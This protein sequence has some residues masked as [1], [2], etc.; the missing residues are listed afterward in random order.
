MQKKLVFFFGAGA[1]TSRRP[2]FAE[3]KLVSFV[4]AGAPTSQRPGF[5]EPQL[6][7]NSISLCST[8]KLFLSIN[9]A[10]K[11]MSLWS[12]LGLQHPSRLGSQDPSSA[13]IPFL[14]ALRQSCFYL[15]I[16]LKKLVFF[17]G[18]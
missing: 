10:Q 13:E 17:V 5:A 9:Y 2:G 15:H 1:P 4:G 6:C 7:G 14:F 11:S 3:P 8:S 18:A 16:M 12:E